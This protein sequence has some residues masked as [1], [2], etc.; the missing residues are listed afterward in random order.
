MQPA[1]LL[2]WGMPYE[3]VEL[4]T[5]QTLTLR[6]ER[7]AKPVTPSA[8]TVSLFNTQG[9]AVVDAA[10]ATPGSPSVYV[11]ASSVLDD[12]DPGEGWSVKWSVTVDG[13]ELAYTFPVILVLR[14]IVPRI[15]H[16]DLIRRY[17]HLDARDSYA[18]TR[19][20]NWQSMIDD[21][22][23]TMQVELIQQ[24]RRPWLISDYAALMEPHILLTAARIHD[25]F[26]ARGNATMIDQADRL[27]AQYYRAM[28]KA[29]LRY[30]EDATGRDDP[31]K[32]RKAASGQI[33]ITRSRRS[34]L[35]S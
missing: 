32:G 8:A 18:V 13:E 28:D 25:T 22:W 1:A 31:K 6:L 24:G 33:R 9:E 12:E 16:S 7:D 19:Q 30:A 35:P 26:G 27:R 23:R 11:L 14:R 29:V 34:R 20:P 15:G 2:P 4:G 17:P 10:T 5:A 3:L 21:A